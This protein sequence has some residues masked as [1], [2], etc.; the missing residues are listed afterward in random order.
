MTGFVQK[1]KFWMSGNKGILKCSVSHI[2]VP[3]SA[4]PVASHGN[5][6]GM[7]ILAVPFNPGSAESGTP[8]GRTSNLR[9]TTQ[10]VILMHKHLRIT[11]CLDHKQPHP[12][13]AQASGS[14]CVKLN[15]P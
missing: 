9:L 12:Q 1:Y 6:L 8:E 5:I 3:R 7:P 10:Q 4:A 14:K 2:S 15:H 13:G 11:A